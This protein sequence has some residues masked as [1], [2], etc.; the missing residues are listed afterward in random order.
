MITR[1]DVRRIGAPLR[2]AARIA[3][4][5]DDVRRIAELARVAIAERKCD[6]FPAGGHDVHYA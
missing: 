5:R 4:T 1:D 3:I 2:Q 6:P